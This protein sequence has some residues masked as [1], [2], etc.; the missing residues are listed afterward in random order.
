M[1]R[2]LQFPQIYQISLLL[3]VGLAICS[4]IISPVSA[5]TKYQTGS[6]NLSVSISGSNEFTAGNTETV[7]L[8]VQNTGFNTMKMVQSGIVDR[9][10]IPSTAK[11]VTV[12]LDAGD[13]PVVIKSD[14]QMIGDVAASGSIPVS[15]TVLVKDDAKAGTYELPATLSYTYLAEADQQGTDSISYRYN[16]KDIYL[17][18]P[19]TVKPSITLDITGVQTESLNAGGSGYV[20]LNLKNSGSD[21]GFNAIAKLIRKDNSPVV[22]V[23]STIY[24]GKLDPETELTAKFKVSISKDAEEQSY[25]LSVRVD[26]KNSDGENLS[27]QVKDF[28]VQVGSKVSF[29]VVSDPATI[30]VGQK[31][32]IEVR[33]KNDGSATAYSAEARISAVDPFTSNDDLAYLGDL[34]PGES[35]VAKF[36]VSAASD[37]TVKTYGLDSEV[38]YRDALDNSQIS[39]TVKVPIIVE[40]AQGMGPLP[41]VIVVLLI[42]GGGYYLYSKRRSGNPV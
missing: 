14:P 15:F 24:I 38:R 34:K 19:F 30:N 6:P 9:D 32:V 35:G 17:N 36:E 33:Y 29:S 2:K 37:A 5:G 12:S 41:G 7:A 40:S 1:K 4:I 25:P 28:G 27:T 10:D 21:S 31:K 26:Y 39:D 13:A 16:K 3:M 20:T 8:K 42:L 11:M 22:P 23:D 18:I